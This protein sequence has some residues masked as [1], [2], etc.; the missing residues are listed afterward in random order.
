MVS[1][2]PAAFIGCRKAGEEFCA[3][4]KSIRRTLAVLDPER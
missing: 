2:Y 4:E 3:V 1:C